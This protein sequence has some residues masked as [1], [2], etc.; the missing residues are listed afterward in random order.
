MG[1]K[2][3]EKEKEEETPTPIYSSVQISEIFVISIV[4]QQ[5]LL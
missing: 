5:H 3:T 1:K 4:G 2:E